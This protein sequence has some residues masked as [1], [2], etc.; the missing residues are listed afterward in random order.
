MIFIMQNQLRDVEEPIALPAQSKWLFRA[1]AIT[2]ASCARH[3][4]MINPGLF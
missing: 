4:G 2:E 1:E 3:G